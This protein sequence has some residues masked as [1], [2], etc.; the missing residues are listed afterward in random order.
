MVDK[1][2][3]GPSPWM[4]A[5]MPGVFV[6]LWSTGFLGAKFG[7]PYVE[8]LTFLSIRFVL[9]SAILLAASLLFSAPW[10]K[11]PQAFGHI[12]VAGVLVQAGYLGGVF[13]AIDAGLSAGFA[14]LIVGLQPVLTA[15]FAGPLFG[16]TINRRQWA[17]ITLGMVGLLM[18]L[19]PGLGLS[20]ISYSGMGFAT[21]GLLGITAGT[22]YQKRFCADMDLRSG[23][24]IQFMSAGIVIGLLALTT[25]TME[26][27]WTGE[28]IFAVAWLVIVLSIGAITL[29]SILL[30]RGAA[31]K[32]AS[33]F[34]LV[35]PVTALM[36][37]F[38][39]GET[40]GPIELAGI[41]VTSIGVFLVVRD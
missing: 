12:G 37:F 10:P 35:T 16:E 19:G 26:V 40:L 18:V 31:S 41:A 21:I 3:P 15:L 24:A 23:S 38:M 32:V 25:E 30:R 7:L 20:A 9:V 34:Y 17:G 13:S 28:L 11:S 36:A 4:L 39:F 22:L 29:L 33:L 2:S 5:A 14:A 8:P 1:P 27:R 6:F